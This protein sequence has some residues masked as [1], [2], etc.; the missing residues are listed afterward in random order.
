MSSGSC[1]SFCGVPSRW[2]CSPSYGV[3][4]CP[5]VPPLEVG[6]AIPSLLVNNSVCDC[7]WTCADEAPQ[8]EY[9][10]QLYP[11]N[12]DVC[13]CPTACEQLYNYYYADF[14][15]VLDTSG[16]FIRCTE[17]Q[18]FAQLPRFQCPPPGNCSLPIGFVN[19][20][21]CD[22]PGTCA[23]E[24]DWD[25]DTCV[26]PDVCGIRNRNCFDVYFACPLSNCTI[27][28]FRLN[29]GRCDCPDCADEN[30]FTCDTCASGCPTN[31]TCHQNFGY[32]CEFQFVEC[33]PPPLNPL[34]L[35]C[36][37][38]VS[39]L[40][41]NFCDCLDCVDEEAWD[42]STCSSGCPTQCRANPFNFF[43][44]V[45][46]FRN[47]RGTNEQKAANCFGQQFNLNFAVQCP[48]YPA[49][50]RLP[51][52]L[53]CAI[54]YAAL[55]DN[56][57]DCPTCRDETT[58]TCGDGICSSSI[59][60]SP[61]GVNSRVCECPSSCGKATSCSGKCT[62]DP[63]LFE[64]GPSFPREC[65]Y[66]CPGAP[67]GKHVQ[68]LNNSVCDCVNCEDEADSSCDTC[69]CPAAPLGLYEFNPQGCGF[70][71]LDVVVQ[72]KGLVD[73]SVG[74]KLRC[75]NQ[76]LPP[77]PPPSPPPP[78]LPPPT[79]PSP[80]PPGPP[81][82]G[83]PFVPSPPRPSP[84][85][86]PLPPPTPP[87]PTPPGP[88]PPGSPFPTRKLPGGSMAHELL[89]RASK[90]PRNNRLELAL[91]DF[92]SRALAD[93]DVRKA[94]ESATAAGYSGQAL[95]DEMDAL[96]AAI[97][98]GPKSEAYGLVRSALA[99]RDVQKV[100]EN[101]VTKGYSEAA[102]EE[103]R[104]LVLM[105]AMAPRHERLEFGVSIPY[106]PSTLPSGDET[107]RRL[108]ASTLAEA[109]KPLETFDCPGSECFISQSR[110]ND[111]VC[112]CPGCED[113][114]AFGCG[115]C[116][117]VVPLGSA[118]VPAQ[119][120]IGVAVGVSLGVAVGVGLGVGLGLSAALSG[121]FAAV[122][123]V[124]FTVANAQEFINNPNVQQGLKKAF[125]RLAGLAIAEAAVT[126]NWACA[127]DA[128]AR[129]NSKLRRL[130]EAVKLCF[131]IEIEGEQQSLDACELLAGTTPEN[132]A[133]VINEELT[134]VS[135][136]E[137]QVVQWTANP[138]PRSK[139]P[140]QN[141][142]APRPFEAP[143]AVGLDSAA[144]PPSAPAP[145]GAN[146]VAQEV[147]PEVVVDGFEP[148]RGIDFS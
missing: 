53:G 119:T 30:N 60:C 143:K 8:Q 91:D 133:R 141:A 69:Q 92:V 148:S 142:E 42:C 71:P 36:F 2:A 34:G 127:G 104:Q 94:M 81:P 55:N 117:P 100:L 50:S 59:F 40:N 56:R 19:D 82:P 125:I 83:P 131:E 128:L 118:P 85:A 135:N 70:E 26:C 93:D 80:T 22:C 45:F 103:V 10:G 58:E 76:F 126:L 57:C 112:D 102:K 49:N 14:S 41:D 96:A 23:D 54:P 61:G 130:G 62:G 98:M 115:T 39:Y 27:N 116:I 7:P 65:V 44:N 120:D 47:E 88:P 68:I 5:P 15:E 43:G 74:L 67:C 18:A 12:C 138:N 139:N 105:K 72:R 3:F 87:S 122:G 48:G 33:P 106:L 107:S 24:E 75:F 52:K 28:V 114:E 9:M 137:V 84:P 124:Q 140:T 64:V 78:P 144:L 109:F 17:V 77:S 35:R 37:I 1:V 95:E 25:C 145:V 86:P 113:E 63:L 73:P 129:L 90:T 132:A 51:A 21:T 136:E 13:Q 46:T 32:Q 31:E 108:Q 11:V 99:E 123:L 121:V 89:E 97:G 111:R 6:C 147:P 101:C 66:F 38:P 79:P 16:G 146:T 110:V 4:Q 29:N 134:A 20:N